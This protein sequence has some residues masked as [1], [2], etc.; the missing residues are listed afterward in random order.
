RGSRRRDFVFRDYQLRRLG[1]RS[2]VS[3]DTRRAGGLLHRRHSFLPKYFAER[4]VLFRSAFWR[5]R[6]GGKSFRHPARRRPGCSLTSLW[7]PNKTRRCSGPAAKIRRW[8]SPRPITTV[9]VFAASSLS[10]PRNRTFWRTRS[11]SSSC[12][13]HL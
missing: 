2:F 4:L 3:A 6:R 10:R 11:R 1:D 8:P 7:H 12:R 5:N 9:I 13:P